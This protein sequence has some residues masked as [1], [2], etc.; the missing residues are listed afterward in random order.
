MMSK[1]K[2]GTSEKLTGFQVGLQ[3]DGMSSQGLLTDLI[4]RAN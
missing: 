1:P 3:Q 4:S 2:I